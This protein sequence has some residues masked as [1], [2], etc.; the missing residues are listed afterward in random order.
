MKYTKK[1][2]KEMKLKKMLAIVLTMAMVFS[3][4][5]IVAFAD[6]A[7]TEVDTFV[8]LQSAINEGSNVKLTADITTDAALSISGKTVTIDLNQKTLKL[9]AGDNKFT[10]ASNINI[11]NGTI[12][13]DGVVVKGNAIICLDEYEKTLVTT[14][15]LDNVNLTGENYSSAY[16]V[17]YIGASSVL[18]VNGGAWTLKNDTHTS[19]GVFKA[20][21]AKATLN[22]NGATMDFYNVRRGV[23]YANTTIKDSQITIKGDEEVSVE[24]EHGFNRSPLSIVSSTVTMENLVGRGI[25]AQCG[26]V[27][28]D[29]DSKVSIK[30][31][32]EATIDI[33]NGQTLT[34]EE[35]AE[36]VVD[37]EMTISSGDIKGEVLVVSGT[38]GLSGTGTEEDPF[39]IKCIEELKWF[40]DDVNTYTSDGSN[41][42]KGKYVK[43]VA[44]IDLYEEDEDGNQISWEPIGL[45]S[46]NDHNAFLGTFDGGNHTISNLYISEN[47]GL[48]GF[49]AY[50]GSYAEGINPTVKNVTF[51]NVDVSADVTDHWTTNHGDYV[52]GVIAN[53]GGNSIINNVHV[54]GDVYVSGCAY[55]G[56]IVGHGYPDIDNCSVVAEDGSYV[57][58]G[59][60]CAG[61]IIGYAGEGGTPITN[62][63]VEGIDIWGA[64][65]AAGAVAGLLQDGNKLSNVS[66]KNVE[67]TGADY[68][69]GYIAGNGSASTLT[70]VSVE[71]VTVGGDIVATDVIA[72]IGNN[73]YFNLKEAINAAQSGDTIE[74]FAGT[75]EEGSILFPAT[76]NNVTIKGAADK[77]TILKNTNLCSANGSAVHYDGLTIDNIVFDGSQ[78]VFT[79]ARGGEVIYK[80]WTITNCEFKNIVSNATSAVH[81]NL[82]SDEVM[83]NFT[84]TNNIIDGVSGGNI[85]GVR[86]NYLTGNVTISDN[87]ISNVAWNAV[88]LINGDVKTFVITNNTLSS[89]AAEGILN[90][91]NIN[92][93][94]LTITQNKFL[95]NEGQ[96]GIA[97][98]N[99]GDV[100]KN[101]WGG[102][103]P[104]GLPEGVTYSS[105]Y[106]DVELT[107]LVEINA[108]P[109]ILENSLHV[110]YTELGKFDFGDGK[111]EV[112]SI[113]LSLFAGVDT[114]NYSEA[115]FDV[116]VNGTTETF[117]VKVVYGSVKT[118][119][120][121]K[122]ETI[123]ASKFGKGVNYIFGQT[124][125]FPAT[126]A[127]AN[128]AVKW[129]PYAIRN[130][131]KI[132]GNTFTLS[133]IFPGTL[134]VAE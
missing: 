109:K 68:C 40:R 93:E 106:T 11:K 23:T 123:P 22:I 5:G 92:A 100:S 95:V 116:T 122:E 65:G 21:D 13:I 132:T 110:T 83:E 85:S 81:F 56:G 24:M 31:S 128:T 84:F 32:Q 91:H 71:N 35:G 133:D 74:I 118:M 37:K 125:N 90:L 77:A 101:Y 6:E 99:S 130:K 104:A 73:I 49:F 44:D 10:D 36:V 51:N 41:Q 129:T 66:A 39:I 76:L 112:S 57:R 120:N 4:M 52:G 72:T 96:P 50:V 113:R 45:N 89:G 26:A 131:E 18:N 2:G 111:G 126:D 38:T 98:L 17:F 70:N 48:L 30:N 119:M 103:A 28:I 134:E 53:A 9:G 108:E 19:G 29:A 88:Q 60:W 14:V 42:Y 80:D 1:E 46:T 117:P 12:N 114:L 82:A 15:T 43:L 64:Y 75:I 61:G 54:R 8:K 25:T 16:G 124:I 127:F 69:S 63:S 59:Y 107:N 62:S 97:Y 55:V 102:V 33:R 3:T 79:G 27:T 47:H 115:G 67:V 34:V 58:A 7:V 86:L 105:Y 20:D 87:K 78:I 94:A 121:G